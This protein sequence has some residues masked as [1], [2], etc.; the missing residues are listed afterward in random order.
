MPPLL[1]KGAR[2]PDVLALQ[3]QLIAAGFRLKADSLFG[4]DTEIAVYAFQRKHGLLPDG[5]AGKFTQEALAKV[6][7]RPKDILPLVQ[8]FLHRL[9]TV[10]G[11]VM[12]PALMLARTNPPPSAA[13]SLHPVHLRTSDKGL[14]FLYGREAQ[15]NVSNKLHW[16]KGKSGVTLGPG[17]DMG[18]RTK[19]AISADLQKVGMA[20]EAADKVAE[21]AGL[22][23]TEAEKFV[24]KFLKDNPGLVDLNK[25]PNSELNLLKLI[26]PE[27]ERIV[28]NSITVDL[29]HH[30]FDALVSFAYNPGGR[31]KDVAAHI[32]R[33]EVAAAMQAIKSVTSKDPK[34]KKGLENRRSREVALYLSGDYGLLPS[35]G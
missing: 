34:N 10:V 7:A 17:Y 35:V 13:P 12:I 9:V 32:N 2:G 1:R 25:I 3:E 19:A 8:S 15:R 5:L 20:K 14:R 27:Y 11:P 28:K 33:G 18:E 4:D 16:P 23:G 21:A 29:Y 31:F 22:K 6:G 26:V 30:Q 24:H